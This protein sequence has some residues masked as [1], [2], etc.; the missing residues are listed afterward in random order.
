MKRRALPMP[1]ALGLAAAAL[2]LAAAALAQPAPPPK[3]PRGGV[4]PRTLPRPAATPTPPPEPD[5]R[6]PTG[7]NDPYVY[8]GGDLMRRVYPILTL[9]GNAVLR[10]R[11]TT[12]RSDRV[13]YNEETQVG[14]APGKLE[15]NDA[16]NTL[17]GDRGEA[18]YK[19]KIARITG[20]VT[21]T[22][23][24]K[25]ADN[26]PVNSP[27][28]EFKKPVVIT[29]DAVQYNWKTRV[30]EPTGNI[31]IRC[32]LRKHD[33]TFTA[34]RLTYRGRDEAIDLAGKVVGKNEIGE[35]LRFA[36]G[37]IVVKEGA[38]DLLLR[39]I[40]PGTRFK[41]DEEETGEKPPAAEPPPAQETTKPGEA[42]KP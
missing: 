11:D 34:D 12:F 24:P 37:T 27:R 20:N 9:E 2:G 10:Y 33:W 18:R 13:L 32:N 22:A 36:S 7:P 8:P 38:E 40:I 41:V 42:G 31:V 28:R 39:T 14:S 4:A 15:V 5:L 30:A 29:C 25:P 6:G 17:T 19:L 3:A 1:D 26:A 35:E 21:I 16:Q 23:R